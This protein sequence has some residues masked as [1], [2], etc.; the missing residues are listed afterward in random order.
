MWI[1]SQ[2]K[3]LLLKAENIEVRQVNPFKIEEGFGL[4]VNNEHYVGTFG[5]KERAIE[6]LNLILFRIE[7]GKLTYEI[8]EEK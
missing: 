5:S 6:E 1:K 8:G 2:S 4:R 7:S 3:S